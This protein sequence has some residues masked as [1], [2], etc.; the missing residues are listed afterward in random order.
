M[1]PCGSRRE[2]D[3][4][5]TPLPRVL[6]TESIA[7][8]FQAILLDPLCF[9]GRSMGGRRVIVDVCY[10]GVLLLLFVLAIVVTMGEIVVVM[11]MRM[12]ER[13]VFPL[14]AGR[15]GVVVADVVMVVRVGAPLVG[16]LGLLPLAFG[17]LLL[18]HVGSFPE[19]CVFAQG[20][21]VPMRPT[22]VLQTAQTRPGSGM[23]LGPCTVV[24]V[25]GS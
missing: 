9:L 21:R 10:L 15:V 24:R 3:A 18:G 22:S 12:P 19:S 6:L 16:M 1:L 11:L 8:R 25:A 23:C 7:A 5:P 17:V 20:E 4:G 2:D 13:A 14:A